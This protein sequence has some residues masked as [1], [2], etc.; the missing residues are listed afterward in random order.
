MLVAGA[1]AAALIVPATAAS[2]APDETSPLAGKTVFLDPGHQQ[3]AAGHD[4]SRQVSDGRGGTKDCQTSGMTALGGTPEYEIN[5]NVA[6]IV[7][8]ALEKL[9]AKVVMSRGATGWGGCITDRAQAANDSGA[10]LAVSIHADSTSQGQDA[11]DHGF[12]LIIPTLPLPDAAAQEAQSGGGRAAS[13]IMRDAYEDNGFTP[14][15]YLGQD[16]LDERSDI[17]GPALTHVPLVFV[18]MGNGSN[19][20]DAKVL[21]SADGQAQNAKAIT[22]GIATYLAGGGAAADK[23]E[24]AAEAT[25]GTGGATGDTGGATDGDAGDALGD[26]L[27]GATGGALDG[28]L[29]QVDDVMDLFEQVISVQGLDGL[30]ALVNDGNIAKI[31]GLAGALEPLLTQGG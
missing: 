31:E 28:L 19:P 11:N 16:G 26:A 3:S 2:A 8:G 4:M 10:D 12:H 22:V 17:A 9:G 27:D 25:A 21:E 23:A 5:Y 18:E 20:A 24:G 7:Q 14:S 29:D 13:T 1:T 30:L 6:Q 15:N